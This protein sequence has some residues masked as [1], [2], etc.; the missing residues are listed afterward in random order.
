MYDPAISSPVYYG[1]E[2][3]PIESLEK[4]VEEKETDIN[5]ILDDDTKTETDDWK[6]ETLDAEV[7]IFDAKVS[8]TACYGFELIK[9]T[10]HLRAN[11]SKEEIERKL[12]AQC[13]S[14][15]IQ[16]AIISSQLYYTYFL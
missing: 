14:T 5:E 4:E 15:N 9:Q 3:R 10:D 8:H 7:E 12:E 13:K 16:A 1:Y 6:T 2:F 11:L